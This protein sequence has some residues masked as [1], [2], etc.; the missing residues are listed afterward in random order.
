MPK[1]KYPQLKE[2]DIYNNLKVINVFQVYRE[3]KKYGRKFFEVECY[4]GD[5]FQAGAANIMN[6]H[7]RSCGCLNR[8]LSGERRATHGLSETREYS[9][10]KSMCGRCIRPTEHEAKFY[11]D[12]FIC[13]R[14]LEPNG[15]GFLNFLEDMGPRP[16]NTSLDRIDPYGNYEPENCRW[17]NVTDQ[18]YNQRIQ[19]N[20]TSG[21]AGVYWSKVA[22]KWAAYIDREH[23]RIHIG[24]FSDFDQAVRARKEKEIEVYGYNI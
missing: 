4:C 5:T 24:L 2:G 8:T 14:W 9:S 16:E 20:N 7:T 3:G 19:S 13:N 17:S 1:V 11:S 6:G 21:C 23:K 18:A 22:G 10:W 15:Q 12:V